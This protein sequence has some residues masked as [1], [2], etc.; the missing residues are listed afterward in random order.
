MRYDVAKCYI[1]Y[2]GKYVLFEDEEFTGSN[3][4][5]QTA[6]TGVNNKGRKP[7]SRYGD[8]NTFGNRGKC[9]KQLCVNDKYH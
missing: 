5:S 2:D 3:L 7:E 8:A 1:N 9:I 4:C 6:G